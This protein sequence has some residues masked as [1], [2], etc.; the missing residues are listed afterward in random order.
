MKIS[1]IEIIYILLFFS[2][3]ISPLSANPTDKL[4]DLQKQLEKTTDTHQRTNLLFEISTQ[5]THSDFD[6]SLEY[7][8]KGL[9]IATENQD[10]RNIARINKLLGKLY[11]EA[12]RREEA[13]AKLEEAVTLAK[14][15]NLKKIEAS[16]K[17]SLGYYWYRLG[18][19]TKT[20]SNYQSGLDLYTELKDNE[21]IAKAY[22]KL[23]WGYDLYG[24]YPKAEQSF[25]QA[26]DMIDMVSDTTLK[27]HILSGKGAFYINKSIKQ[28]QSIQ[29]FE[30]ALEL[31]QSIGDQYNIGR[32]YNALGLLYS[33]INKNEVAKSFYFKGLSIFEEMNN[34]AELCWLYT[35]IGELYSKEKEFDTALDYFEKALDIVD[36]LDRAKM[37]RAEIYSAIG[38]VYRTQG[39]N[40]EK[41]LQYFQQSLEIA[42][43]TKNNYQVMNNELA[44][45]LS[46]LS[47]NN[48]KESQ[49]W[50]KLA[51]DKAQKHLQLS[52]QACDCLY[53]TSEGLGDF[54]AALYYH[55][56]LKTLS[57]TLHSE[58]LSEQINNL[59]AKQAYE[60]ELAEIQKAQEIEAAN[61]R[62]QS[63][64]TISIICFIALLVIMSLLLAIVK[65]TEQKKQIQA[66]SSIRKEMIAN[67]SHDLRTPITVMVGYIETLLI[68]LGKTSLKDQEKYLNIILS[69]AE[70]LSQLIGKLFEYSKLEAQQIELNKEPFQLA[71]LV[72]DIFSRYQ[73]LAKKKDIQIKVKCEENIPIVYADAILIE[74]VIQNLMDNALKFTPQYGVITVCLSTRNNQVQVEIIDTGKGVSKEEEQLIFERYEK[75]TNSNG[76]GLGLT[77]VKNILD[78]HGSKIDV[79]S[80]LNKGTKFA[81][82]LPAA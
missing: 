2:V 82:S 58:E 49:K 50:C 72:N 29:Y 62:V 71:D 70:H 31:A 20:I 35:Q 10:Y 56:Q 60:M 44:I 74:R 22:M 18:D 66:L 14:K 81:F 79:D 34:K 21:G 33:G 47:M 75:S 63:I 27:M 78:L 4:A 30:Q 12:G 1:S 38:M 23:G 41:A 43:S 8:E 59:A 67:V 3:M 52:K 40:Y 17:I 15:E 46:H 5:L 51:L 57:D 45:G 32:T 64:T 68:R 25:Q 54:K 77:I 65:K 13:L 69:S 42:K 39:N 7:A 24:N 73:L 55:K 48:L 26:I 28:H 80:N 36:D 19:S 6:L 61:M 16:T 11:L 9:Q 53:Q 37:H 76:A